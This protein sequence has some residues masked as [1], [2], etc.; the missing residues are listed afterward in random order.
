MTAVARQ[1]IVR[2]YEEILEPLGAKRRRRA[3]F[4]ARRL[5]LLEDAAPRCL[6][7]M[8]GKTL[9]T[10]IVNGGNLCVYRSTEM[11]GEAASLDPHAMLDEIFPA[12][13]YY[14]DTW[15]GSPDRARVPALARATKCSAALSRPN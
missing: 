15:G 7:R 1:R 3:Q 9:T 10:V 8:S 5:P 6:A 2:E 14:Q 13:A 11:A 12:I 4:H